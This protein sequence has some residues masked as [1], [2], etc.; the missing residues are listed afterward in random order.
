MRVIAT[1]FQEF[2]TP[3]S[4]KCRALQ[5]DAILPALDHSAGLR[6]VPSENMFP[7]LHLTCGKVRGKN[8]LLFKGPMRQEAFGILAEWAVACPMELSTDSWHQKPQEKKESKE[9]PRF[10]VDAHDDHVG[11]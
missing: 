2:P 11:S 8:Q 10:Q 4:L 5:R 7:T 1:S 6:S 9:D 3:S